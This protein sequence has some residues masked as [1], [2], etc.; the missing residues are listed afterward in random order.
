MWLIVKGIH[1]WF[2]EATH[3]DGPVEAATSLPLA[4]NVGFFQGAPWTTSENYLEI[5]KDY[6]D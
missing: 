5:W 2:P 1:P 6:M 3:K 4:I